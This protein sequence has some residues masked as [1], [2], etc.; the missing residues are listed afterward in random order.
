MAL[1]PALSFDAEPS[2]TTFGELRIA[3]GPDRAGWTGR[4]RAALEERLDAA[5]V[6]LGRAVVVRT[7]VAGPGTDGC[8][9]PE[10]QP[11]VL[12]ELRTVADGLVF[13]PRFPW[14]AGLDYTVCLEPELLHAALGSEPDGGER[15]LLVFKMPT[16]SV[17]AVPAVVAVW[18]GVEEIPANLLR[19]YVYFS[20]PMQRRGVARNV[21]LLDAA[22]K[23]V[24]E[25][26]VDIPDGL[27]DPAGRRLT[28]FVHP[29]R[30][31]RGVGPGEALGPV[32][33]AGGEV[34]L[35]IDGR[36]ETASG[37]PLGDGFR[38][39][40]RVVEADR[41]AP[42]PDRWVVQQ[43]ST[44]DEPLRLRFDEPL[45]RAQ[46]ATAVRVLR[47]GAA[48][49]GQG[50]V[51]AGGRSWS[52]SPAE[53]WRSGSYRIAIRRNLEDLAGN[54]MNRLFDVATVNVGADT[55]VEKVVEPSTQGS[56]SLY[57][58]FTLE[59]AAH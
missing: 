47:A 38:Q 51:Q 43:P 27:W 31:K 8:G 12:G 34:M 41:A 6:D 33:S 17:T 37:E 19:F 57:L 15:Q 10:N 3:V 4:N 28:V 50:D 52:F 46:V 48:L 35:E 49:P 59:F 9:D 44:P 5:R 21:R 30:I 16:P 7:G 2:S 40:Y 29:G 36:L 11:S 54:T 18:P 53:P 25:P 20:E 24:A 58:D 1:A 55:E 22:G 32:L 45:D 39:T 13:E 23:P 26:F 56:E 14:V 42:D